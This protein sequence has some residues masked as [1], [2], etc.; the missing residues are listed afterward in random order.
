MRLPQ[1]HLKPARHPETND[2][3]DDDDKAMFGALVS[4]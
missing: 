3:P 1:T 4:R 2:G